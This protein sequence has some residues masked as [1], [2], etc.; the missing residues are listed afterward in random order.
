MDK[1]SRAVEYA[2]YL[3]QAA[4]QRPDSLCKPS[5]SSKG[6]SIHQKLHDLYIES[7]QNQDDSKDI[8]LSSNLLSKL[9]RRDKL[10][11]LILKLYP[12]NEGYSVMLRGRGGVELETLKLPYEVSELLDYVDSSELPPFLVD[13]LEKAQVNVFYSGCV[14]L[15]VRDYRRSITGSYDTQYVLLKPTPQSL[16]SDMYNII[17]DGHRWTQEDQFTLESQLLLATEEP[18]CLDPSPSVFLVNNKLQYE[19][20]RL[21]D[22]MIK[23]SAKR[24]NQAALN[25]K[26]KFASAAAPKELK[27]HDFI[28][29]KKMRSNPPVNLKVGKPHV[30]MW[31]QKPLQLSAPE[32]VEVN[33]FAT[34]VPAAES[35]TDNSF[36]IMEEITLERDVSSDKKILA[37]LTIQKRNSDDEFY[38]ELYLD[39]DYREGSVGTSCMFLLGT[40]LLV[41]KYLEQFKEIFTEEGRRAVKITTQ[42]PGHPPH[43]EFTQTSQTPTT[44]G[45]G[46]AGPQGILSAHAPALTAAIKGQ[47]TQADLSTTSSSG[48][49]AKRNVPIQLSLT[50]APMAQGAQPAGN[51][52]QLNIQK[53]QQQQQPAMR[54]KS[55]SQGTGQRA[56]SSTPSPATTPTSAPIQ[57]QLFSPGLVPSPAPAQT[58]KGVTSLSSPPTTVPGRKSSTEGTTVQQINQGLPQGNITFV[59][60]TDNTPSTQSGQQQNIAN[61][62]I[63]NIG[64]PPN[65]NIQNLTGLPGVNIANLQGLQ[66]MQVSLTGVSMPGGGIAVPVPISLIN[67]NAGVIQNQ[68]IFVSSLPSGSLSSTTSGSVPVSTSSSVGSAPTLVTMVTSMP[69]AVTTSGLSFTSSSPSSSATVTSGSVTTPSTVITGS[70]GLLSPIIGIAPFVQGGVKTQPGS[71]IRQPSS[72]PLLQIQGQP[73]IQLVGLPQQRAPGKSGP[74]VVTS[75]SGGK[76][77]SSLP[78]TVQLTAQNIS[79]HQLA[80]LSQFKPNTPQGG[81]VPQQQLLQLQQ[82]QYKQLQQIQI[83][84][85][86]AAA[87]PPVSKPKS[88]KRTT[89]TPPKQ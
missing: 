65:I 55:L 20:K 42:K 62:N 83:R 3:V 15:E 52:L 82:L 75:Q 9:V 68:N 39:H 50:L 27:L 1:L 78:T 23:R 85:P 58:N 19:Q 10:N 59:Q 26:R 4:K 32:S 86:Q 53:P 24:Y 73:G 46:P 61:I 5:P 21:C 51:Q 80:T 7:C 33:K 74:G 49:T 64:L 40:R 54:G 29:K 66:N 70:G 81:A 37:K 38:G 71:N 88:K 44:P 12:G 25:R 43:V 79:G 36:E 31:K 16:L 77:G 89:P 14:I 17:N 35:A 76:P 28:H 67:T 84:Q 41:D 69:T 6:K 48:L 63:T 34:V 57:G 45:L 18:L 8:V 56:S 87:S 72:V 60:N 2:E 22:P 13:L 47:F 11:C 30:D